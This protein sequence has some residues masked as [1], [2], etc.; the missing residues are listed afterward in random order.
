MSTDTS[1]L[2]AS[3]QAPRTR[4]GNLR[5][6]AV[7]VVLRQHRRAI[8]VAGVLLGLALVAAVMMRWVGVE[9]GSP[10]RTRMRSLTEDVAF[11]ALVGPMLLGAFVA[12]PMVA[13]ELESG[14]YKLAWAQGVSP[15]RWL[16]AKLG[17]AAGLAVAGWVLL[18]VTYR[19]GLG[20][21][22]AAPFQWHQA[23]S[24]AASGIA[25]TAYA[26]LGVAFG[27]L[28]ALLVR[29]TVVAMGV[30]VVVTG[31]V[32]LA[33]GRIREYLWPVVTLARREGPSS[34]MGIVPSQWETSYGMLTESGRRLDWEHCWTEAASTAYPDPKTCMAARGAVEHYSDV[35]P[36]SH[37]WPLQLV[38]TGIVVVLGAGA[39]WLA[40]RV[41]RRLHG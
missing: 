1:T 31:G 13:R 4:P 41:L 27:A 17:V 15:A 8:Q 19:V 22:E 30:T 33:L 6:G 40:F 9:D 12:G 16:V 21:F 2:P 37:F 32:L 34:V 25:G 36:E 35:H 20:A 14:T 28:A 10:L 3:P 29:R 39:V 24:Y 18:G 23:H 5:R 7:R 38:E 11:V 26:L